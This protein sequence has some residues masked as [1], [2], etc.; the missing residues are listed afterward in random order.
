MPI[1]SQ[2]QILEYLSEIKP[3]LKKDGI[4]EIGLF[5]SYAD[6]YADENSDIDIVVL[7]DKEKF[8]YRL[9]A[10]KALD[11]LD[12][13]KNKISKHFNKP[14]DICDFYSKQEIEKSKIVK[15]AIYV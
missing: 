10:F 5:G 14:V 15:G 8:L 3:Q 2:R 13:L 11:Y 1:L 6:G 9:H 4:N 12:Q 7:A